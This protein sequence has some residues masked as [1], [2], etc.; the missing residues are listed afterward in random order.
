MFFW[1]QPD[2][3][4]KMQVEIRERIKLLIEKVGLNAKSFAD[5]IGVDNSSIYR[6]VD[7]SGTERQ[8][9]PA[10]STLIKIAT[11]FPTV[12]CRWLLTGE[13]SMFK[14]PCKIE[15]QKGE[16]EMER[17]LLDIIDLKNQT[18]DKQHEVITELRNRIRVLEERAK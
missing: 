3:L 10:S 16:S 11:A 9:I 15:D 5:K 12:D 13:G 17:K 1:L 8:P 7:D 6:I 2:Y 14:A 4:N 18:V